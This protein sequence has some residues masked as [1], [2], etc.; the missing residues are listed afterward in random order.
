MNWKTAAAVAVIAIVVVAVAAY[1]ISGWNGG[2]GTD[3]GDTGTG[4]VIDS[5][6][7]TVQIPDSL[8]NGI[9]VIGS[10][11]S[12]LRMLSMFD[13][14]DLIIEV[15]QNEVNNPLN[16]RGYAFAYDF[17]GMRYHASNVLEG[18]TV[19]SIGESD[20]SLIIVS[21][22]VYASYSANVELL[23][24]YYP[25]YVINVDL[26]IWDGSLGGISDEMAD[27]ITTLGAL[28]GQEDRAGELVDGID[29]IVKDIR[30]LV[31]ESDLQAFLAGSNYN[32]TNTLNTTLAHYQPF[33]I[34]GINNAY[35]GNETGKI[36]IPAAQIGNL[37]IDIVF[38]DPS[39][40]E[41]YSDP[42]S[43]AVMAYIH[44]VNNDSDPDN[45][46][47]VRCGFPVMG[48]GTNFD[49]VLVCSYYIAYCVYGG[50]GW[51]DLYEKMESVYTVFYGDAGKGVLDAMISAYDNRI[52]QFGQDFQPFDSVEVVYSNGTYRFVAEGAA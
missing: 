18:S 39:T 33:E 51:D 28:L 10:S 15:D 11:Q 22:K 1:A 32:G 52:A 37:D 3:D 23:A 49:S 2:S 20:P 26:D 14:Y 31:G 35:K 47:E 42:T 46:I 48:F 38:L 41:K 21:D 34:A 7:R 12:P 16:G 40:A 44:T 25:T 29:S 24:Q 4:T 27:A 30:N 43:Q 17:T 50:I 5:A 19:Q 6:G 13:T 9:V 36:E 45:D 8:D